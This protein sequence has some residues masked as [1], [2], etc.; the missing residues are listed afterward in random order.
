MSDRVRLF[1]GR[2]T[3]GDTSPQPA[4]GITVAE[5]DPERLTIEPLG[6][7][8]LPE[9]SFLALNPSGGVLYAV[10]ED[11][12]DGRAAAF[13]IDA[14]TSALTFLGK[15]PTHGGL[16]CHLLVEPG[17]SHLLTANYAAG[18]VAVHPIRPD[19]AL[20]PS[21]DVSQ[22]VGSGPRRDRQ[23]GPHAHMTAAAPGGE[24]LLAVDLGTDSIYAY[25]LDG[26]SGRLTLITQNRL[27][28]GSG[29]RHL[30]FH[31][32]GEYFYLAN[33]LG[34][35]VSVCAYD[36]GTAAVKELAELP[37]VG[38]GG[39]GQNAPAGIVLSAD[40]RFAY[41]SN[42]GDDSITVFEVC[43]GGARL[44]PVGRHPC[45]GSRPRHIVFS[46]DGRFLFVAN[47]QSND[48]AVLRLDPESGALSPTGLSYPVKQV[49]HVIF[50]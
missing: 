2:Y 4:P 37:A 18:S 14:G 17:G 47:Q 39:A 34:N 16:P 45:G 22:H 8:Q 13:S 33:E 35:S 48:I 9:A 42:R 38:E 21:S 49:A 1:I 29:P 28:P 26:L 19:G 7:A 11:E 25:T 15:Q 50:G 40:A 30:V 24:V 44:R 27:R 46:P 3:E 31:P 43:D 20:G 32:S 41:L 36:P 5:F 6:G 23:A 10:Q 12:T